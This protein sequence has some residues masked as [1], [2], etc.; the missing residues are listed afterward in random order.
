M[1][2]AKNYPG[3]AFAGQ[4]ADGVAAKSISSVDAD[5]DDVPRL[6]TT[7]V[8]LMQGLV[9]QL[10]ISKGIRCGSG[11]HIEPPRCNDRDSKRGIAGIYDMDLHRLFQILLHF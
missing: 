7:G 6:N 5:A 1:N 2:P 11:D 4:T 9:A 8:Q 3:S 10:W